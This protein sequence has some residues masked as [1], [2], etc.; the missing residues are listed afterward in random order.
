MTKTASLLINNLSNL[1]FF[2]IFAFYFRFF[3]VS[4]KQ[5]LT[6]KG[7]SRLFG[8]DVARLLAMLMMVQGH[9]VY[10]LLNEAIVNSDK[11]YWIL[12]TFIRGFTA[13]VFLMVSGAVHIFA[14]KRDA[15]GKL[16]KKTYFRRIRICIVLLVVGYLQQ[17][18]ANNIYDLPYMD[19]E[20]FY[21]FW[22]SNIL[23]VFAITLIILNTIFLFTRN[24][25]TLSYISLG[26]GI[27]CILLSQITMQIDWFEYMPIPFASFL[28]IEHGSI[29]P[30]IPFSG[31]IF[32]GAFWG[33]RISLVP[34]EERERFVLKKGI[35]WGLPIAILGYVLAHYDYALAEIL[36]IIKIPLGISIERV[37][38]AL[39]V[40]SFGT[41][42]SNIF[43]RMKIDGVVSMLSKRA[44]FIYVVHLLLIYGSPI[45]PGLRHFFFHTDALTAFYC[46]FAVIFFSVL[47]VWFY[48]VTSKKDGFMSFYKYSMV[49][50]LIYMLMI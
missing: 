6:T 33:Y 10:C 8:L 7:S 24:N 28:S 34:R 38:V 16:T 47:L 42:I 30:L 40:M 45:S 5:Y 12:W 50:L 26:L 44:L 43:V 32:L 39:V 23:Q 22:R 20:S 19:T 3:K 9:T 15:E 49:A 27:S 36:G 25:K 14:N 35:I 48:D 37:G 29:F 18:P 46:A 4:D 31:Y 1:F 11:W 2:L 21:F 41:F 13:P 17:F